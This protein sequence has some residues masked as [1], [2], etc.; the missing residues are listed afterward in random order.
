MGNN[1]LETQN[2]REN[3]QDFKQNLK[4]CD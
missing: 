4:R 3:A 2:A 1:I